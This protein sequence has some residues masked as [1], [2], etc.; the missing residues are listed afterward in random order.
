VAVDLI[1]GFFGRGEAEV[2]VLAREKG[3]DIVLIDERKA[4]K[5]ARRAG[6]RVAGILG[7]L[8]IAKKKGL[9]P[10]IKPLVEELGSQG[11]RLGMRVIAEVLK[12]AG[13]L[14]K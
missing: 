2:L 7:I 3:A 9:V 12:E 1:L 13:E 8:L 10:F 4:R 5:A 14:E 11:F 6:F